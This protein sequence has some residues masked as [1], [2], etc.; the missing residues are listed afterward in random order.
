MIDR[1]VLTA[2]NVPIAN[3][4]S[5]AK[6]LTGR[7]TPLRDVSLLVAEITTAQGISGLGFTYALRIGGSAQY[8]LACELAPLLMGT[9]SSAIAQRWQDLSWAA[10]SVGRCGVATQAIAAFDIALW[11]IRARRAGLPVAGLLG[12]HREAVPCYN[13][14]G[15]YLQ[16]PIEEVIERAAASLA[17]GIG[18]IKIK[19]GQP[20]NTADLRRVEALRRAIGETT[21]LMAD[22]NQQWDRATALR[23][24]VA[25]EPLN[26]HWLEEPLDAHDVEGHA[27][28]RR[29]TRTPIGSGE[30]LT[31]AAEM[32]R[33]ITAEAIDFAM[34]DAPRLGGI[35]PFL[36][37]ARLAEQ[38]RL[39][40]APHFVME[41]HIHLAAAYPHQSW[42]EHFEWLQPAFEETL[43][44]RNGTMIVPRG[45][46]LSLTLHERTREWIV[47]RREFTGRD[48]P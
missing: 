29:Q 48:R 21:P 2:L 32:E 46:G 41:I 6:V 19:V 28:L 7:Q 45:P 44:I 10:A 23:M 34:H 17:R 8:A 20:D 14:S 43:E 5:D 25:L 15:G 42:V 47:A 16:A 30:M 9:D 27:A 1:I 11:D 31:T 35:T 38:R 13:S 37:V 4:V 12:A 33:F 3:P 26:L 22:A 40:L 24:A 18:G 39:S 36:Q